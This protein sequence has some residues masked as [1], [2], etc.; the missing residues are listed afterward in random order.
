MYST[1]EH[2]KTQKG[3][4]KKI[5]KYDDEF[6]KTNIIT[7]HVACYNDDDVRQNESDRLLVVFTN[8]FCVIEQ[9]REQTDMPS[10]AVVCRY[11]IFGMSTTDHCW[12]L[13]THR[14][15]SCLLHAVGKPMMI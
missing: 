13:C 5:M 15:I 9:H 14:M 1:I 2:D 12:L 10:G 8:S 7:C 4:L 11:M 3:D 6:F